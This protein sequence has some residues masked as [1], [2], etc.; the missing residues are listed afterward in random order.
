MMC[1]VIMCFYLDGQSHTVRNKFNPLI[2]IMVKIAECM[3]RLI[4]I[5]KNS[6][7]PSE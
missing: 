1:M 7:L 5:E 3:F 2:W 6:L 4:L